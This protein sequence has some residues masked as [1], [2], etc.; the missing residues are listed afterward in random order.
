M[1]TSAQD[2]CGVVS[3]SQLRGQALPSKRI[4]VRRRWRGQIPTDR[5]GNRLPEK[6]WPQRRRFVWLVRWFATDA[7]GQVRRPAKTFKTKEEA[8][9]FKAQLEA[10]FQQ[11]PGMRRV[12]EKITLG[13][14]IDQYEELRIVPRGERMK[15]SS[16]TSTLHCL[17]K[18]YKH[19]GSETLLEQIDK[20]MAVH[21]FNASH[22][23]GL[24][25][26]SVNK[27]KRTLR[28]A[29]QVAIDPCGY[30]K[31]NPFAGI[32]RDREPKR[33]KRIVTS[34]EYAALLKACA[35]MPDAAR[36]KAFLVVAYTCGLRY[37]E[38]INLTWADIDF[39]SDEITVSAKAETFS[40]L[41][42]SSKSYQMRSIPAPFETIRLLA[43]LQSK[44]PDGHAYPFIPADRLAFIQDAKRRGEWREGK[45][46]L[47]NARRAWRS[48]VMKAAESAPT[49]SNGRGDQA[50]A[51]V[52]IHDLRKTAIT[53]WSRRVNL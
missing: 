20:R 11:G 51:T 14:F 4:T 31:S 43:D 1:L 27:L 45:P 35:E 8:D 9:E 46:V 25:R 23:A 13:R 16:L 37:D 24:S 44:M 10:Q 52:K 6:L 5:H 32:K 18:L 38:I 29:F 12:A 2:K 22:E 26:A 50:R 30:I 34:D 48:I 36:W 17:R 39:A 40:T 33:R 47:N 28:A 15:P 21:F 41:A 19:I 49:L 7:D 42:W 3:C 53:N